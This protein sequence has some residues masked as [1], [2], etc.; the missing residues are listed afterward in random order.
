MKKYLILD[1]YVDEPA[2]LGVPPFIS[3]YPRYIAGALID[4]GID[5]SQ[6]TYI[7]IDS[8][9]ETDYI[10]EGEYSCVF[11][12]GG[13]SVPGKYLGTKIGTLS[14][15]SRIIERNS[16]LHIAAGGVVNRALYRKPRSRNRNE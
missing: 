1:C 9:R 6:I 14:E 10:I 7:T 11:L 16:R 12:V 15:I 2:C 13:A 8:L 4:A 5:P 3:P